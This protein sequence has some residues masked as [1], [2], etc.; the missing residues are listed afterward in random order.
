[1]FFAMAKPPAAAS[2]PA[3]KSER[4]HCAVTTTRAVREG[5]NSYRVVDEIY[6]CQPTATKVILVGVSVVEAQTEVRLRN[7]RRLGVE[8]FGES[9]FEPG[10][11]E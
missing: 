2:I 5:N 8:R 6:D 7:E 9:G 11:E 3:A 10:P 4:T 1:M